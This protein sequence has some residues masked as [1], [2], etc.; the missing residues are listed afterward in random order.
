[1]NDYQSLLWKEDK[2]YLAVKIKWI[3]IIQIEFYAQ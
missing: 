1:M 3:N 2:E